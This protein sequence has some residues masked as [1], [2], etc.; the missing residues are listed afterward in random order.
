MHGV[1][2]RENRVIV[3][4]A[5]RMKVLKLL[6]ASHI[7]MTRMKSLARSHVWWHNIEADI[8][9]CFKQ[10]KPCAETAPNQPHNIFTWPVPDKPWQRLHIDLA[11]PS[12]NDMWLVVMDAHSKWPHVI[13]LNK[14]PTAE[15]TTSTLDDLF[16]LW[17]PPKTIG[18]DNGPQFTSVVF[19]EW[20]KRHVI[21]HLPSAPFHP[22]F[23]GEAKRLAGNTK[24]DALCNLLKS[25]RATQ[26]CATGRFSKQAE[27]IQ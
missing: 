8:E 25:Y 21:T 12:M 14:Y 26:N 24:H 16:T 19:A 3:P 27:N 1:L 18:S 2:L 22:P 9:R 5:L 15:K 13:K 7:G 10:Y 11:G 20:C 6:H 4:T 23:N 17:G